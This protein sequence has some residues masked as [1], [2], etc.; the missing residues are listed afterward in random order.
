MG[1]VGTLGSVGFGGKHQR[2]LPGGW[3]CQLAGARLC[4]RKCLCMLLIQ[5]GVD[6]QSIPSCMARIWGSCLPLLPMPSL[7]LSH[8]PCPKLKAKQETLYRGFGLPT[9]LRCAGPGRAA[10][11]CSG[12]VP[13][14][15]LVPDAFAAA[16]RRWQKMQGLRCA[17]PALGE[18][19]WTRLPPSS[20][21][22]AHWCPQGSLSWGPSVPKLQSRWRAWMDFYWSVWMLEC[23]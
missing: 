22:M 4:T 15:P 9:A 20:P 6:N 11:P 2:H 19:S 3:Q 17:G 18:G 21:A 1:A 23:S 10:Q 12:L 7:L 5:A 13:S 16:S 14:P 8:P